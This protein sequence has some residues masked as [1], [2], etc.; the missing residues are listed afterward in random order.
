M[1]LDKIENRVLTTTGGRFYRF[2]NADGKVW[3]MPARHM[4][5][6][7][8][9]Y[10]PGGRNG[11]LLKALL[12]CLHRFRLLR[13]W[14]HIEVV[15]CDLAGELKRMCCE[16]FR[17]PE[18]E[19]ALFGGT[20]SVHR[21][22]T[23]QLSYC[24]RIVGYVKMTDSEEIARLFQQEARWLDGLKRCGI[25]NVPTC[26][27]C[28]TWK[29][30]A[31]FVQDTIKSSSSRPLHRWTPLQEDFLERLHRA[32]RR[33]VA[34]EESDYCATLMALKEHTE[35]LPAGVDVDCLT[36]AVDRVLA[37]RS[38]KSV[39]YSAYHADFTPWNMFVEKGRLFVF[40][41]EYARATYPP[42]LDRYH[43]FIQSAIYE[44]HWGADEIVCHMRKNETL[45]DEGC[46]LYLLEVIARFTV[47]EQ[48]KVTGNVAR[49]IGIWMDLLKRIGA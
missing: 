6:A 30:M 38:G 32:T 24:G 7:M 39:E 12:P 19:F 33:V 36:K 42:G 46:K 43:F 1:E 11:K 48:A 16:W 15:H 27:H 23:M 44:K 13:R 28:G 3:L 4:R 41:W 31:L 49:S 26:L 25:E 20:P 5:L 29:G 8:Q 35:W 18:V 22:E 17:V 47:R 14:L 34:F 2:A 10:Q 21:K 37:D 9:L 40:D 45:T